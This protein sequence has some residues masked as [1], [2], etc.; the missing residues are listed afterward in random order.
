MEYDLVV[1]GSSKVGI[2]AAEK[3]TLLGARVALVTLTSTRIIK[4]Q[5]AS[6]CLIFQAAT[7]LREQVNYSTWLKQNQLDC[8]LAIDFEAINNIV[9]SDLL[10]DNSL[11]NLEALGVDIVWGEGEFCRLPQQAF[12]AGKR[13]LRSRNYLITIQSE[14]KIPTFP[15][16]E[17]VKC[18]TYPDVWQQK[19]LTS[20]GNNVAVIGNSAA[21]L[22]LAQVLARLRKKVTLIVA[23]PRILL[24]EDLAAVRLIQ[25]QLEADGVEII[26]NSPVKQIKKIVDETWLQAGDKALVVDTIVFGDYRELNLTKLNLA[27]VGVKYDDTGITINNKLQT[28]NKS[29]YA[30][31]DSTS[32]FTTEMAQQQVNLALKNILLLPWF[33]T[34]YALIPRVVFTTPTLVSVGLNEIEAKQ[35]Y[36]H[37][38]YIVREYFKN[39]TQSQISA[40]NTGWCQFILTAPGE[41]L[42]CTIIGDRAEELI[43]TVI[44]MMQ[45]KIKLS[46]NAI[47]G[48]LKTEIA[49]LDPSFSVILTKIVAKFYQQKLQKQPQKYRWLKTWLKLKRNFSK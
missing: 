16:I 18:L 4:Q 31:G 48:L 43:T 35:N 41:I 26:P 28:T 15:G 33:A 10:L 44:V 39:I 23:Q 38:I 24:P 11:A 13:K 32:A 17:L 47:R 1:I 34:N 27:G 36:Q 8:Q 46:N 5:L 20:L 12:I 49:T 14:F 29:I 22:V 42:G 21:S 9:N 19:N 40:Q 2:E 7:N 6:N 3:A 37:Q 30:C 25:A 45:N